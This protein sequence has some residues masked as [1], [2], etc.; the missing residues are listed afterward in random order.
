[1][2]K[3][4]WRKVFVKLKE[5]YDEWFRWVSQICYRHCLNIQKWA[6]RKNLEIIN[7]LYDE[8]GINGPA[9][10]TESSLI[11]SKVHFVKWSSV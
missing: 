1:V 7:N 3:I 9:K 11:G 10:S 4:R 6:M 5:R 8:K 2:N